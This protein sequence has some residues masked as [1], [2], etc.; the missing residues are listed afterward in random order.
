MLQF[1]ARDATTQ[2]GQMEFSQ[3]ADSPRQK[4]SDGTWCLMALEDSIGAS[5]PRVTPAAPSFSN[6]PYADQ[7][8]TDGKVER[9]GLYC[10]SHL[11]EWGQEGLLLAG[12]WEG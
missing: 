8:L 6:P 2:N 1:S 11:P 12:P 5:I 4:S 7:G 3:V 9:R 10:T